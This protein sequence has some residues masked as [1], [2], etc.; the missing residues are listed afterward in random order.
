[1]FFFLDVCVHIRQLHIPWITD[2]LFFACV[3][4]CVCVCVCVCV[5]RGG[6]RSVVFTGLKLQASEEA[7]VRPGRERKKKCVRHPAIT[8]L[9]SVCVSVCVCV[10]VCVKCVCVCVCEG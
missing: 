5:W 4:V 7:L 6:W 1:M 9:F 10:C 2:F 8:A 3:F